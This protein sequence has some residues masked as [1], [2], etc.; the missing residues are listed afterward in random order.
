[1]K[2][3]SGNREERE[4]VISETADEKEEKEAQREPTAEQREPDLLSVRQRG[5]LWLETGVRG[6]PHL[7][8]TESAS[9]GGIW[10]ESLYLPGMPPDIRQSSASGSGGRSEPISAGGR[11]ESIRREFSGIKFP[12][13]LWEKLSVRK[14]K[15][16]ITKNVSTCRALEHTR[17]MLI[18][19]AQKR[20]K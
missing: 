4:N 7:R 2:S 9:V 18:R 14:K 11:A 15:W 3:R 10:P 19:D 16:K 8:R 12:G 17:Y 13:D 5:G 6:T 1:M 20:T